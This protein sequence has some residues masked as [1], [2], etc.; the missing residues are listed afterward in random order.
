MCTSKYS[1]RKIIIKTKRN[2][3]LWRICPQ[4]VCLYT[5]WLI[6]NKYCLMFISVHTSWERTWRPHGCNGLAQDPKV[7]S[8]PSDSKTSVHS[9][10]Y[11]AIEK[12]VLSGNNLNCKRTQ[13]L[14]LK[15]FRNLGLQHRKLT[16]KA[17]S[18]LKSCQ[19]LGLWHKKTDQGAKRFITVL[20]YFN[21]KNSLMLEETVSHGNKFSKELLDVFK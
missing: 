6:Q 1:F 14:S 11:T 5:V 16:K 18:I 10:I 8:K 7:N 21:G 9:K 20:K 12:W 3:H 17:N 19:N 2:Q 15:S 13:T 4:Q